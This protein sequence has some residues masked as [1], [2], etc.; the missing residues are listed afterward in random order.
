MEWEGKP[1]E[2]KGHDLERLDKEP[3]GKKAK[4]KTRW[5]GT[6]RLA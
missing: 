5:N 6:E 3:A 2:I 1:R 4:M